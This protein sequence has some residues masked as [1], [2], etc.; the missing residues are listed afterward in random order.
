[1]PRSVIGFVMSSPQAFLNQFRKLLQTAGV[2]FALTSG[3]ACVYYGIQQTTKDSDWIIEP[4]DLTSFCKLLDDLDGSGDFRVSLRPICG[5]PIAK[6]FLRNG[7]TSHLEITDSDADR[8][9]LDFFGE[10]PRVQRIEYDSVEPDY[11]SR[12][13]VAQMKKTDRE[14]DWPFVFALGRQSIAAGDL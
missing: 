1:M 7:W 8:H 4:D 14:K 12:F 10:P 11:A 6:E 9:H 2:R 5:A 13:I 3:Q